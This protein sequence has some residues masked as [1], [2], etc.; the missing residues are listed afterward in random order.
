MGEELEV[1]ILFDLFNEFF[2][3]EPHTGLDDQGSQRHAEGFC[4]STKAMTDLCASSSS[5][6]SHG[7][8][9]ASLTEVFKRELV[10]M[11]TSVHVENSERLLGALGPIGVHSTAENCSDPLC[12]RRSSLFQEA[13]LIYC[14]YTRTSTTLTRL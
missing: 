12:R 4:W 1:W 3:R 2:I 8:N 9:S 13:L 10:T 7:I 11:S 14:A 5:R 6:S